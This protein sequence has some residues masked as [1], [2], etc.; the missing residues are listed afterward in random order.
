[1]RMTCGSGGELSMAGV[2]RAVEA[3][4]RLRGPVSL[5]PGVERLTLEL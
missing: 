2:S 5:G 3:R 4:G 1:M